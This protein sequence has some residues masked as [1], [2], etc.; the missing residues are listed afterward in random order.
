MNAFS[1][2]VVLIFNDPNMAADALLLPGTPVR[3]IRRE[4]D[5]VANFGGG[6]FVAPGLVFDVL[7]SDAPELKK[8]D[9]FQIGDELFRAIA[10]PRAD[11]DRVVWSV[12][13]RRE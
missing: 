6:Q 2:A 7:V 10:S 11:A 3:V 8:D 5:D 13:V 4:P 12:E 1:A 9:M